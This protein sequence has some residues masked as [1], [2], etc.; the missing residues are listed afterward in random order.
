MTDPYIPLEEETGNV[1]KALLLVRQYGF[2]ITLH[3]KSARVLRDLD[4]LR[5]IH[6]RGR[7]VVQMTLTTC[8]GSWSP[9]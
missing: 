8:A 7:C 3:T 5:D 2:G 9:M 6:E 4:L 1:R